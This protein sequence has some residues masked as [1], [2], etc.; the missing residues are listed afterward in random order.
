MEEMSRLK[1]DVPFGWLL[2]LQGWVTTLA[3]LRG[4]RGAPR[5]AA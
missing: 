4:R 2:A 5:R 3:A 1:G